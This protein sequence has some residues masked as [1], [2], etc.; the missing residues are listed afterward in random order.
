MAEVFG[1]ALR[2]L[3]V[4]AGLS[5]P[6]LSA[7]VHFSQSL[8]SKVEN[9]AERPSYDF[10]RACDDTLGAGG[11]LLALVA[12]PKPAG[13]D[14]AEVEAW[15]LADALTRSSISAQ[16]LD[17]M[18]RA[19]Y[20]HALGYPSTPPAAMLVPVRQQ[21][22]R[23]RQALSQPQTLAI[24]RR[25]VRL[26]GVLSGIAGNLS[27]DTGRD[28]Q[29]VTF[30]ELG[31]LAGNEADDGDL[32]AWV[33]ATHSIA[34]FF[35]GQPT[36]AATLLDEADELARRASGPRRW[37]WIQA[38][39]ARAHAAAG[40]GAT[41]L[42]CL[43]SARAAMDSVTEPPYGTDFFDSPRLDG[44]AGSTYLLLRDPDGATELLSRALTGRA[45]ADAKGRALLTLDLAEAQVIAG[46]LD[47]ASELAGQA[48]DTAR[49]AVV[50]PIVARAVALRA[51]MEPWGSTR[52]AA[53]L[54]SRLADLARGAEGEE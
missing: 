36:E 2:R 12:A 26:V 30:F 18:E 47:H 3:R 13:R 11:R 32:T 4:A 45:P 8:I 15:E 19:V 38:H 49:G 51:D 50:R 5:Q 27:V 25:A 14:D 1:E 53:R 44:L 20:G 9:G 29:A 28:D 10:A 17:H 39:R 6:Q 31:R 37:A 35:A 33:L 23:L 34:P 24:R 16:T 40:D 43:D 41:A 52:A 54:D 42:A 46:D 48:L 22:R 21:L 7:A